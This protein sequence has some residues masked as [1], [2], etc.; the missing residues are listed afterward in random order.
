MHSHVIIRFTVCTRM[1]SSGFHL[2]RCTATAPASS[3]RYDDTPHTPCATVCLPG[4]GRPA[5]GLPRASSLCILTYCPFACLARGGI[6]VLSAFPPCVRPL[7]PCGR[8]RGHP[9]V[10]GLLLLLLPCCDGTAAVARHT[11]HEHCDGVCVAV[12]VGEGVRV[13][14]AMACVCGSECG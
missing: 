4:S 8:C 2:K 11:L 13:R 5:K 3:S 12:S 10:P 7:S 14:W 6:L 1:S 9:A